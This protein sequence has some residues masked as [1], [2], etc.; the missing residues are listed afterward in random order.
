MGQQYPVVVVGSGLAGL[1]AA[2]QLAESGVAVCLMS[3]GIFQSS[4]SSWAQ[5]G[6]AAV[7][8]ASP[9]EDTPRLHA[10]D[11]LDAG[12]GLGDPALIDFVTQQGQSAIDW[13]QAHGVEFTP[14]PQDPNSPHLTREGGHSV[15]RVL[16]VG[17]STGQSLIANCLAYAKTLP[18]LTMRERVRVLDV[19]V[20]DGHAAGVQILTL[21]GVET[22][23]AKAVVLATGGYAAA[24]ANTTNPPSSFGS[25][26]AMAARV[27]AQLQD[28]EFM[29]FHPTCLKLSGV[30][31]I[32]ITEALRGEGAL[33]KDVNGERFMPAVD[34]RAELAPRDIVS[35][36]IWEQMRKTNADHVLLDLSQM[37]GKFIHTHFPM[38][39]KM[40]AK[41]GLDLVKDLIP[42][43]PAAHYGL[44]GI[45]TDVNG[46]SSVPGLYAV[47][48]VA[49]TGLHGANRL[50]SNSL[51][52]CVVF[53][54]AAADAIQ[55]ALDEADY[56]KCPL[57]PALLDQAMRDQMKP[58]FDALTE[59]I[60]DVLTQAAG[61]QRRSS[62]LKA[63]L[64]A[65][66]TL[67]S[68]FEKLQPARKISLDLARVTDLLCIAKG[69]LHAAL[70]RQTSIGVHQVVNDLET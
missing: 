51:L 31:G 52:E 38:L 21:D 54:V 37:T 1:V 48:E 28:L 62:E 34:S 18:A 50:A 68:L 2:I 14:A 67:Q 41:F 5:G 46:Q 9:F 25:G 53:G 3:S 4:A 47:G 45:Q 11:T 57:P 6:I 36:A 55:I 24:F 70:A 59:Q 56:A 26:V 64:E 19:C 10:R 29:Q 30:P 69:I 49:C 22:C 32:L 20:V 33:L 65:L 8:R 60:R 44:G 17:D 12:V 35:R 58:Q 61:I 43:A 66:S 7:T 23:Q 40:C 42:V 15:R 13:L 16:H 27:G 63:A 39:T